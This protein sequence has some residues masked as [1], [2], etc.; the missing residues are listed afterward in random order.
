MWLM[1][2]GPWSDRRRRLC[3]E[4]ERAG[5]EAALLTSR[6]NVF[7]L[8]GVWLATGERASALVV[9]SDRDPVW[10]VHE[11]FAQE[12][13]SAD[14]RIVLWKDGEDAHRLIHEEVGQARRVAV[15]G[16]WEARHLMAWM[17]LRPGLPLPV[18]ADGM[19]AKLRGRKDAE[20]LACLERASAMADEVVQALAADLRAGD[21]EAA[22]AERLAT[23]W[24]QAGSEGMSFPP[25]VAAGPNGA[26]PHHEPD[27][28]QVMA[29][30]TV[31]V[32]TGGVYHHYVSDITRTYIVGEPTEEMRRVYACVLAAQE[33]G[34]QAAKP[35]VTLGEVDAVVRRYIT[36][37]GYGPYFTH[38]TGHG[39]GLDIH[40]E[41][42]VVGGNDQVLEPGMV[43]SIEPGIYLP[44]R[45]GVRIE[46]LVVI[47]EKGARSLNRAP[48]R[49][50]AVCLPVRG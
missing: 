3:Q 48:K 47:E 1:T 42:Y 25:I 28:S 45:F 20:E 18:S 23:L 13:A 37:A 39:V 44:G 7:Y 29:G 41:P 12:V 15:D 9:R 4:M 2:S 38:R 43:M 32:D 50:E 26:A 19:M 49:W 11:M 22:L 17:A 24:R 34:I 16:G 27:G 6:P 14:V 30:T 35:G 21:T 31:I 46:D 36:D 5:V 8:T 10:V 40:E 33:A